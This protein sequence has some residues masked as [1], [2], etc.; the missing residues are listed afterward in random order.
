MPVLQGALHDDVS[1]ARGYEVSMMMRTAGWCHSVTMFTLTKADG[2]SLGLEKWMHI[3]P[4]NPDSGRW[5]WIFAD[6][7]HCDTYGTRE[8]FCCFSE[9]SLS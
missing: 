9:V 8:I 4:L 5:G 3:G 1:M 2:F 6:V 7:Y